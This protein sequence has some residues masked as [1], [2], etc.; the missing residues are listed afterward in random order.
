MHL[1]LEH[2]AARPHW[3]FPPAIWVKGEALKE[4][5]DRSQGSGPSTG[6]SNEMLSAVN[7]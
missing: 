2:G 1:C 7:Q 4:K 5:F 3:G 6:L